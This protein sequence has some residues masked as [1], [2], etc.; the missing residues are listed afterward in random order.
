MARERGGVMALD[1]ADFCVE[2]LCRQVDAA[3]A[4]EDALAAEL[5]AVQA[6]RRDL[7]RRILRLSSPSEDRHVTQVEA[8]ERTG[9]P[10]RTVRRLT[11]LDKVPSIKSGKGRLVLV[12]DL[13]A[14]LK[15]C[16]DKGVALKMLP[17]VTSDHDGRRGAAGTKAARAHSGRVRGKGGSRPGDRHPLGGGDREGRL[18]RRD[19]D[20]P[21][22]QAGAEDDTT[23]EG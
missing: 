19:P 22:G 23:P 9:I 11:R 13:Q 8:A 4:R 21:P 1:L 2:D 18:D 10:L 17:D 6:I 14:A 16:R 15:K 3:D 7:V 12:A 20:P 5:H